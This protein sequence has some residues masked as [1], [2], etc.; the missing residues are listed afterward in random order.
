MIDPKELVEK[1]RNI[2]PLSEA[3][4]KLLV[5]MGQ[6]NHQIRDLVRIVENEP[7]LTANVLRVANS[8]SR[9]FSKL[10]SVE[11]HPSPG[12]K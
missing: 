8:S 1:V 6:P 11:L 5:L 12:M 10:C 2:K 9:S 3:T 7:A 4:R